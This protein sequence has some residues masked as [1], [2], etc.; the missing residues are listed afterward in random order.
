MQ[1]QEGFGP[2]QHT[3]FSGP[4]SNPINHGWSK[5]DIML[6]VAC[7]VAL[8]SAALFIILSFLP[9]TGM[10]FMLFYKIFAVWTQLSNIGLTAAVISTLIHKNTP[11]G[12]LLNRLFEQLAIR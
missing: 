2:V 12:S 5:K 9:M 4:A 8:A 3:H 10:A 11:N 7:G 6:A 1:P